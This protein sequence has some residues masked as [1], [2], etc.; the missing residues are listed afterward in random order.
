MYFTHPISG[1]QIKFTSYHLHGCD[2]LMAL[3]KNRL[4]CQYD[5][6]LLEF[7]RTPEIRRP[8]LLFSSDEETKALRGEVVSSKFWADERQSQNVNPADF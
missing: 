5:H 6:R 7:E 1:L 2:L 3:I 4:M 8:R